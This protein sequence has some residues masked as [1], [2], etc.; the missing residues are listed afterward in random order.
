MNKKK[1][2][3]FLCG[4]LCGAA[5]LYWYTFSS[6]ATLE[7]VQSWLENV[8]EEYR[9]THGAP[10]ADSGWRQQTKEKENRL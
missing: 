3:H 9:S 1:M 4:A 8:A 2:R 10:K 7:Q 6:T 5:G